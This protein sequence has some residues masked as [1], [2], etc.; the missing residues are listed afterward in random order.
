[1]HFSTNVKQIV[2]NY[3]TYDKKCLNNDILICLQNYENMNMLSYLMQCDIFD[4]KIIFLLIL[5]I[6]ITF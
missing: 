6:D 1:M 2:L 3:N 4:N 5:N